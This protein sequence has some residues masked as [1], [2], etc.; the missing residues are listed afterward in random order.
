MSNDGWRTT[1]IVPVTPGLFVGSFPVVALLLQEAVADP[2][3]T[4]VVSA[5]PDGSSGKLSPW[6]GNDL[7]WHGAWSK[8]TYD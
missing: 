6:T 3:S 2:T 8:H 1:Q 4:R 7:T 5:F